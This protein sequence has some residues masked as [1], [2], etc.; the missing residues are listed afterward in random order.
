[1]AA[2]ASGNGLIQ[3]AERSAA[4]AVLY[5]VV[6]VVVDFV[7]RGV[8]CCGVGDG[9]TRRVIAAGWTKVLAASWAMTP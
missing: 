8:Q 2:G 6:G 3:I 9:W 4:S 7:E 5:G 1:M